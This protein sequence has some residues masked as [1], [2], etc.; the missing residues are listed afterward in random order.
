MKKKNPDSTK[1]NPDNLEIPDKSNDLDASE[2]VDINGVEMQIIQVNSTP[3][4]EEVKAYEER[5]QYLATKYENWTKDPEMARKY[6]YEH[7]NL[8]PKASYGFYFD[9]G[10]GFVGNP[11]AFIPYL[12]RRFQKLPDGSFEIEDLG[13][14]SEDDF[15]FELYSPTETGPID[16]NKKDDRF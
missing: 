3:T 7:C 14:L 9:D 2:T 6:L 15:G 12:I 11:E 5:W 16:P 4:A 10:T 13:E 1:E 8:N